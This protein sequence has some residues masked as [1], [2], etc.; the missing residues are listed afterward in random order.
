[1]DSLRSVSC[2]ALSFPTTCRFVTAL[3][4][5]S[6]ICS[7]SQNESRYILFAFFLHSSDNLGPALGI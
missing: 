6:A 3:P 1:M 5:L 2:R 4:D 7:E